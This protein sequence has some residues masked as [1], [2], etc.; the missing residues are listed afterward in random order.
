M[1]APNEVYYCGRRLDGVTVRRGKESYA[2][3]PRQAPGSAP[4]LANGARIKSH[5][6]FSFALLADALEDD[7]QASRLLHAFNQR[8]GPLLPD[9]WVMSRSRVR[10]YAQMLEQYRLAG[11]KIGVE[12]VAQD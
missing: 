8:V 6:D 9:R 10:A 11:I 3:V 7:A 5:L 1:N 12:T 4:E 2:L